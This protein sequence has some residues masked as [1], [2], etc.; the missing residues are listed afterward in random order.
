MTL[1]LLK[2]Y[3][4]VAA[5]SLSDAQALFTALGDPST[6]ANIAAIERITGKVES[7]VQSDSGEPL[8]LSS[9]DSAAG[10]ISSWVTDAS[11]TVAFAVGDPDPSNSFQYANANVS[12]ISGNTRIG[13][14][15]LNGAALKAALSGSYTY[16]SALAARGPGANREFYAQVQKTTSG[17]TKTVALLPVQVE[18]GV[19][20]AA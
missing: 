7:L 13:T 12:T 1:Y 2:G 18:P 19:I 20:A 15:A 10:T 8:V 3:L 9:I 5:T 14:I 4:D 16:R 6:S 11:T 17:V